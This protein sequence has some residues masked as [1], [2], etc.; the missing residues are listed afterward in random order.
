MVKKNTPKV[1]SA[2]RTK[3]IVTASNLAETLYADRI[4]SGMTPVP[5]GP[6]ILTPGLK[7]AL[8]KRSA[9]TAPNNKIAVRLAEVAARFGVTTDDL[10]ELARFGGEAM[11]RAMFEVTRAG[12]AFLRANE[13]FSQGNGGDRKS[14]SVHTETENTR[15]GFVAWLE[16]NGLSRQRV[17]EAMSIAKFVS[18]MEPGQLDDVLALGKTKVALLASLSPE[19]IDAAA[20]SGGVIDKAD[21]MTVAELKEE[22]RTLKRREKNYE[23]EI[24]RAEHK[25][26]ALTGKERQSGFLEVTENVR[27]ECLALQLEAELSID[28]LGK[29][30]TETNLEGPDSPEWRL[31]IEQIWITAHLVSARAASLIERMRETVAESDMPD[32]IGGTHILTPEESQRWLFDAQVITAGHAERA[33]DRQRSRDADRPRGRG[34]PAGSKNKVK[35]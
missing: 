29:L 16:E 13:L 18:Q 26:K 19:V 21:L 9:P 24:E 34:R 7:T 11:N 12:F 1:E 32:H 14:V 31:R 17:Y 15:A 27:H 35:E 5:S 23:A 22:I 4:A 6:E 3:K 2:G 10:G 28:N 20:E 33:A 8:A 25:L 30:Y